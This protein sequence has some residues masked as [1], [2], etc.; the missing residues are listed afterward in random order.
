[1]LSGLYYRIVQSTDTTNPVWSFSTGAN[2]AW[3][4]VAYS[5]VDTSTPYSNQIV[6]PYA[7]STAAK[8]TGTTTTTAAG[9]I[10]S[11]FGDR[12]AGAY[13]NY[14]DTRR[15]NIKNS[16]YATPASIMMQ[17]S[18]GD[19]AAGSQVR[20]VDG[21]AGTGV[22]T[23]FILRLN[24]GATST[25]AN[26]GTTTGAA[27][28]FLARYWRSPIKEWV[29]DQGP[30]Y[31][32]H[33]GGS[34][35][36][37]EMTFAAY[38]ACHNYGMYA[39]ELSCWRTSDGVWVGSHDQTTTREFGVNYDIP[40]TTWATLSTLR[41]TVGNHPMARVT[42]ILDAFS[43]DH[44]FF[45]ENKPDNNAT[46]FL[47]M[48]ASYPD[49]T[50]RFVIK[51]FYS[52][53]NTRLQGRQ[54]GYA[55]WGYYYSADVANLPTTVDNWDILGLNYDAT[56][57]DW[58][59]FL[60]TGKPVLGHV[61]LSNANATEAFGKGAWGVMTGVIN[62]LVPDPKSKVF[63]AT[64][65]AA[66][67]VRKTLLR[68]IVGSITPSGALLS[69]YIGRLFGRPGRVVIRIITEA[70]VRMRHRNG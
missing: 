14:T 7:G 2:A 46:S 9:W 10:I 1:M 34:V 4:M 62:G 28:A 37:V 69:T 38:Q 15:L 12:S 58:N 65:T 67:T 26:A 3:G 20:T 47:N 42:D 57:T 59:T 36:N 22:G 68:T 21:P 70:R 39:L 56:T 25:T 48:L 32:A 40:T 60:A 35:T 55:T 16:T 64:V 66:G 18:N 61:I 8:T 33:R 13:T 49:S 17:D 45:I 5:G 6:E 52:G 24:P 29:F 63:T 43:N 44:L 31:V 53:N 54:Q 19:V 27:A 30:M 11:G 23:S 50:K 51:G 41:T